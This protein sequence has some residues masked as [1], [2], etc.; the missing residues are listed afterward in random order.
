MNINNFFKT[1]EYL[2]EEF[3]PKNNYPKNAIFSN[4]YKDLDYVLSNNLLKS[5]ND[6]YLVFYKENN[7]LDCIGIDQE[8]NYIN[9]LNSIK[10]E[11]PCSL[12]RDLNTPIIEALKLFDKIS[13]IKEQHY[14]DIDLI[15]GVLP[16][17]FFYSDLG[18]RDK[19][20]SNLLLTPFE[21]NPLKKDIYLAQFE[22]FI[23]KYVIF[24]LTN[25][26]ELKNLKFCS[27]SNTIFKEAL[28]NAIINYCFQLVT[29]GNNELLKESMIMDRIFNELIL[30]SLNG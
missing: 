7:V 8:L 6:K 30:D 22:Y 5:C 13:S 28:S 4:T 19:L 23:K 15:V 25:N 2:Q 20:R 17:Y 29:S 9:K 26:F 12:K 18:N 21:N 27:I 11:I 1:L 16:M 10:I 24:R 3:I 14:M